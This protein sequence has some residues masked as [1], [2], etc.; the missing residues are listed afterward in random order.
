MKAQLALRPARTSAA[1][2]RV[3]RLHKAVASGERRRARPPGAPRVAANEGRIEARGNHRARAPES[4]T[5]DEETREPHFFE[6]QAAIPSST[7][8]ELRTRGQ[9]IQ[10]R[11]LPPTTMAG[12]QRLPRRWLASQ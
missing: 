10:S 4:R 7:S 9:S 3:A 1:R 2:E 5:A 6:S 11:R 12:Q 8:V